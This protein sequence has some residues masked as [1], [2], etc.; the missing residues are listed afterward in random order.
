MCSGTCVD[1]ASSSTNCGA[2]GYRCLD[3]RTCS[4][5]RCTPAWLPMTVQGQPTARSGF[6][7]VGFGGKM[8]VTGGPCDKSPSLTDSYLYD[9]SKDAW[10]TTSPM[11][12]PRS[13]HRM[14]TDGSKAYVFGGL[15][16]CLNGGSTGA[17]LEVFDPASAKWTTVVGTG[18]PASPRYAF[19]M[20]W[21]GS[22]ILVYGGAASA[23]S[24]ASGGLYT[25]SSNSWKDAS[26]GLTGCERDAAN[27]F[28]DG[29]VVRM[30]GGSY[31]D[32]PAGKTYDP[33]SGNWSAWTV[34]QN[35]ILPGNPAM[36]DDGKRIYVL[37]ASAVCGGPVSV[38]LHDRATG[39]VLSTDSSAAP[40][41]VTS[42]S[43]LAW[44]GS[45]LIAWSGGCG[46]TP[47]NGGGRYQPAAQPSGAGGSTGTST[48]NAGTTGSAG[49]GV[50]GAQG[51]GGTSGAAGTSATGTGGNTGTGGATGVAGTSGSSPC[52]VLQGTYNVTLNRSTGGCDPTYSETVQFQHDT[53]AY[54]II[55]SAGNDNGCRGSFVGCVFSATCIDPNVSGFNDVV[56]WRFASDGS[57]TGSTDLTYDVCSGSYDTAGAL[58]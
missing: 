32:A 23:S 39:S 43:T 34:P 7:S 49:N 33:A 50:G 55:Q 45:E 47:A 11:N 28:V 38:T 37:T 20:L 29:G 36:P 58:Q 40:S 42:N 21:T 53:A 44:S 56:D 54:Y 16:D 26:C 35:T 25:V 57:F 14:V 15:A 6:A 10:T 27:L 22:S 30:W 52:P 2:C 24:M 46:A 18:T 9:A 48:G 41:G 3:G 13:Q 5:G 51:I 19:S 31:G 17:G 1:L 4:K 12:A 8:M